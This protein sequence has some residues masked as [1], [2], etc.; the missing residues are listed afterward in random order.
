MPGP[1]QKS[2]FVNSSWQSVLSSA[3]PASHILQIYD[4]DDFLSAAVAHFATEGLK[5]G[6][7]VLLTGTQEH[8]AGID[9][10][11]RFAG[12]DPA[13]AARSGQLL[14]SDV[15]EAIAQAM[16]QRRLDPASLE[17]VTRG[18]L[19]KALF[20]PRFTGVRWW[21]EMTNTL[22][23]RGERK[24][25]LLA[26]KLGNAAAKKYGATVFCSFLC[27]RFDC[28]GYD[29][30]LRDLCCVH[31]HVIPAD[32]YVRHRMAVNRAIAEVVGEIRGTLLQSLSS[33]KGFGCDL[34]SSQATLFW[35]RDALPERFEAVLERARTYHT[36][37]GSDS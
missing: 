26:E 25:G 9:R 32:D 18:A 3:P 12:V 1:M 6:E 14:L 16:P 28:Q 27:D 22:H 29:G 33:W 15:H 11:L 8:L 2:V 17:A 5:A 34:P 10:E 19:E 4:S 20:D 21:A 30:V 31:S 37:Q 23:H 36:E 13:A 24:T 7:V 35:L